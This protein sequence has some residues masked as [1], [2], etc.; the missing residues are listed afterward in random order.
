MS[1]GKNIFLVS[2]NNLLLRDVNIKCKNITR[3]YALNEGSVLGI[4]LYVIEFSTKP[5]RHEVCE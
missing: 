4:P 2:S 5:G 1:F 3:V